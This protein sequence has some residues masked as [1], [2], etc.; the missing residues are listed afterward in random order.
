M[1]LS[2]KSLRLLLVLS[3]FLLAAMPSLVHAVTPWTWLYK[4]KFTTKSLKTSDVAFSRIHTPFFNQLIFSFNAF[5]P[6][7]GKY[8]FSV[9]VHYSDTDMWSDWHRMIEYGQFGCKT[10]SGTHA[11]GLTYSYVR[12]ELPKKRYADGFQI[13]VTAEDG[14]SLSQV[15]MLA[16]SISDLALFEHERASQYRATSSIQLDGVPAWSQ[17]ILD[18]PDARVLCSPTALC[19][20]VSYLMGKEFDPLDFADGV[21]DHGLRVYGSWPCNTV[22][23][24]NAT[25]GSIFFHVQRLPDFN[26]LLEYLRKDTPIVVS[27]R[28][29]LLGAPKSYPGGHLLIVVGYD[30]QQ[31][32]V[33][34]HDSAVIPAVHGSIL[35]KYPL[36]D[37]LQA[38]ENSQ[39]LS[40]IA[41]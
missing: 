12:L 18:H 25:H 1:K 17:M 35:K 34:C 31:Q 11:D 24:F 40:Y 14:A 29:S 20:Q 3:T 27:V 6:E 38:W 33:V 4:K 9:R 41:Q 37:F 2:I 26:A 19:A 21:Y 30:A 32:R 15:K 13:K 39:R 8:I 16:V 7:S 28:G 36:A 22:Y 10:L 5:T 23:A